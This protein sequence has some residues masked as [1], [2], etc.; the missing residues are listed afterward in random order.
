MF[1]A[2]VLF[3]Y[4]ASTPTRSNFPTISPSQ[5]A[6]PFETPFQTPLPPRTPIP[7]PIPSPLETPI[8]TPIKTPVITPKPERTQRNY[9]P[10]LNKIFSVMI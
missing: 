4:L 1:L 8:K 10:G 6:T 2:I 5:Q 9:P 3:L 7:T